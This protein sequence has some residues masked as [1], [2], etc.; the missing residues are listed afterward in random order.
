MGFYSRLAGFGLT[1]RGEAITMAPAVAA[2]VPASTLMQMLTSG[3]RLTPLKIPTD[4][5][6]KRRDITAADIVLPPAPVVPVADIAAEAEYQRQLSAALEGDSWFDGEMISGVKNLYLA[7][8][9][10]VLVLG[11]GFLLTRKKKAAVAGYRRRSRR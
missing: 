10:G 8:G 1:G 9:A 11:G 7:I 5:I 2:P 3:Q 4:G 6:V